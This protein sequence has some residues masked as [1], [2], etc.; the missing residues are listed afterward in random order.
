MINARSETV[1]GKPA[2]KKP[3]EKR[4]CLVLS[5]GFYEWKKSG[6]S[7][8][9]FRITLADG[10]LFAFAGIWDRYTDADGVEILSYSILTTE[11]NE[12]VAQLHNRMP[13]I[14]NAVSE[15]I[16]LSD[17]VDHREHLDL[18]RPCD[19]DIIRTY[20]VSTTVNSP[21]NDSPE[22]ILPADD[23]AGQRQLFE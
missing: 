1:S 20:P 10:R 14:L 15:G 13:V 21:A 8:L 17:E 23:P 11:A 16:W 7:K 12:K 19:P 4:R 3:F 22:L 5:D 9:P 2:F 18:L 6:N